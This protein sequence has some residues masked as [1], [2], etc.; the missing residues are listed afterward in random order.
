MSRRPAPLLLPILLLAAALSSA[1]ETLPDY[2]PGWEPDTFFAAVGACR[3]YR[4]AQVLAAQAGEA[5]EI[6]RLREIDAQESPLCFCV[7]Y[8]AAQ[9]EPH[10]EFDP[11]RAHA[12]YLN[13]PACAKARRTQQAHE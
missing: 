1:D 5:P 3:E 13:G 9:Q 8:Q 12:A 2:Q 11:A 6:G 7:V 10:A 4:L